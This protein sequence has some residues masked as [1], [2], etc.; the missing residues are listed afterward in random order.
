MDQSIPQ[1][2]VF[3]SE[4]T[5]NSALGILGLA[6]ALKFQIKVSSTYLKTFFPNFEEVFGHHEKVKINMDMAPDSASPPKIK[7]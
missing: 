5:V 2:Q 1:S 3:I 6:D 4:M 7:I